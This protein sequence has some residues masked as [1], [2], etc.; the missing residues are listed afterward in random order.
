VILVCDVVILDALALDDKS[1]SRMTRML[2]RDSSLLR[3]E[4]Q[5]QDFETA[6]KED[7]MRRKD[8]AGE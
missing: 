2:R 6:V 7:H 8:E 5:L 1:S 3:L 4:K